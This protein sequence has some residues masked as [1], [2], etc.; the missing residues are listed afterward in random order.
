[1]I[2]INYDLKDDC[3]ELYDQND[4]LLGTINNHLQFEDVCLQIAKQKLDGY[5]FIWKDQKIYINRYGAIQNWPKGFYDQN[6]EYC[7]QIIRIGSQ[8]RKEERL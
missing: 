4:T 1:M 2:K 7:E 5:Y 8:T 3:C 6:V